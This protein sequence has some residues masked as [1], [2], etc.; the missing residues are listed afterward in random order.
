M[1]TDC[2]LALKST[3]ARFCRI[4]ETP[5]VSMIWFMMGS[6]RIGLMVTRKIPIPKKNM[7]GMVIGW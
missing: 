7:N 3:S 5:S 4:S 2:T 6:L 1:R